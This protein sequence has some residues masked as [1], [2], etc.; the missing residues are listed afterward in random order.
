MRNHYQPSCRTVR[1]GGR[2]DAGMAGNGRSGGNF[3]CGTPDTPVPVSAAAGPATGTVPPAP[4]CPGQVPTMSYTPSQEFGE[5]Y[6]PA[7][8]L[9]RGTLFPVLDKPLMTGGGCV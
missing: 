3:C 9:C 6:E 7:Q 1:Y 5:L 8:A 2:F 4:A